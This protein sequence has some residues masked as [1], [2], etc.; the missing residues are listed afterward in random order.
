MAEAAGTGT[1]AS[2]AERERDADRKAGGAKGEVA[3]VETKLG[4]HRDLIIIVVSLLGVIIA[5]VSYRRAKSGGS[6]GSTFTDTTGSGSAGPAGLVAGSGAPDAS[7]LDGLSTYLSNI[8]AELDTLT[9]ASRQKAK[10]WVAPTRYNSPRWRNEPASEKPHFLFGAAAKGLKF[11]RNRR[12]GA[13]LEVN[14]NGTLYKLT[15][16]Q[17][18]L[19]GKPTTIDYGRKPK[20]APSPHSGPTSPS[21]RRTRPGAPRPGQRP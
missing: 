8:Q 10:G 6:S 17:Y 1:A 9:A 18:I 16:R 11:L 7:A 12:T 4:K 3:K 5:W 13:I 2:A 21:R 19:L 15:H 20:P 14:P